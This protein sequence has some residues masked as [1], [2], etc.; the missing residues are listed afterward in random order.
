MRIKKGDKV[1][2][3]TGKDKGKTGK[4]LQ[5]FP[6]KGKISVEG[7]NLMYKNM[8]PR[9]QGEKGQ[10]IQFPSPMTLDKVALVC[11]KCGKATRVGF[12]KIDDKNKVRICSKCKETI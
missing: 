1:K 8:R 4:V 7:I 9:K 10:K 5:V 11:P 12:K 6:K 2:A 3:L